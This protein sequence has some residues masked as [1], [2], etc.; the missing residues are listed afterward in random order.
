MVKVICKQCKNQI[1]KKEALQIT[2]EG[3]KRSSYFCSEVDYN[4][5][6]KIQEAKKKQLELDHI[7]KQKFHE[8]DVYIASEILGYEIGQIVP[9]FLKKRIKKLAEKYE[10]EVIKL[11]FEYLKRDF[12]YY[13]TNKEFED[14]QHKVNYIMVIIENNIN[15]TYRIWKRKKQIE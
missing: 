6:L 12:N 11:C 9:P 10:Y 1:D 5:Y 2:E 3:K 7:E 8:L 15:D 13:L 14:E 4:Q